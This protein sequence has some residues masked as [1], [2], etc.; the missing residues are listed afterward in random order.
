MNVSSL[1]EDHDDEFVEMYSDDGSEPQ[2]TE[3]T[4][5]KA[6]PK[7][8]KRYKQQFSSGWMTDS[9][10]KDWIEKKKH[11]G[12]LV[13]YCRVCKVNIS[14]AKTALTRHSTSKG[15]QRS[16]SNDR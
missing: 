7:R 14:C 10:F 13:P 1:D 16:H 9:A 8:Y 11:D 2:E 12:N 15:T 3:D 5:S 4:V 6:R